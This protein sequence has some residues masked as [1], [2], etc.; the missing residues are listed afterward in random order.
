M[1]KKNVLSASAAICS[2]DAHANLI[3]ILWR[4]LANS[5]LEKT[6][7]FR[8]WTLK[9][10]RVANLLAKITEMKLSSKK[11]KMMRESSIRAQSAHTAVNNF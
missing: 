6:P 4:H 9:K 7:L 1:L 11:V 8:R 3:A 10:T 2:R 5:K